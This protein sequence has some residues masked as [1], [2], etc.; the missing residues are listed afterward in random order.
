MKPA[1]LFSIESQDALQR[2]D[3]FLSQQEKTLS[4]SQIK[5]LIEQGQ[6]KVGGK[7]TKAGLRLKTGDEV[8]VASSGAPEPGGPSRAPSS[9]HP[10]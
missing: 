8:S 1:L 2:L 5:R 4:R 6:V 7:K 9:D 10:I 3:V